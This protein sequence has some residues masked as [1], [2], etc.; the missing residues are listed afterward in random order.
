MLLFIAGQF[1][2]IALALGMTALVKQ[3]WNMPSYYGTPRE[4]LFG[5]MLRAFRT[6]TSVWFMG[7]CTILATWA[8]ARRAPFGGRNRLGLRCGRIPVCDFPMMVAADLGASGIG[9]MLVY[10]LQHAGLRLPLPDPS[11]FQPLA[12]ASPALKAAFVLG[13]SA[14]AGFQEELLFRG[15]LQRALLRAWRPAA[16]VLTT[17]ALF[18][19]AHVELAHAVVVFVSALWLGYLAWRA[20]SIVPGIVCHTCTNGLILS[21]SVFL[22]GR[23]AMPEVGLG[24]IQRIPDVPVPLLLSGAL[25]SIGL[26][27]LGVVIVERRARR[28]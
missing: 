19:L 8:L 1:V 14:L 23:H 10:L 5:P 26:L 18:A 13:G 3:P 4:I 12:L 21:A 2:G 17:A 24:R 28:P 7:A 20:E 15:F 9:L 25:V 16:V 11:Q 22:M 27:A 6:V